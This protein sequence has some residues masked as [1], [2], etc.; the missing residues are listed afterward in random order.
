MFTYDVIIN[1]NRKSNFDYTIKA[2]VNYA[3]YLQRLHKDWLFFE[4][5]VINGKNQNVLFTIK[6]IIDVTLDYNT[7]RFKTWINSKKIA[8]SCK[9]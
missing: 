5:I 1:Y 8:Y 3:E 6:E 7:T 4:K 9:T 2:D